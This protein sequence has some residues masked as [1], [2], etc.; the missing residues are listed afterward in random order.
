MRQDMLELGVDASNKLVIMDQLLDSSPLFLTG[1]T[2]TVYVCGFLDLK[3]DGLTVV[4]VPPRCV[5]G[6]VNDAF[7]RFIV[8]TGISGPD[9]VAGGKYLTLSRH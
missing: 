2:D 8:G 4:K 5:P 6:T 7:F 3:R 9:R 1:N